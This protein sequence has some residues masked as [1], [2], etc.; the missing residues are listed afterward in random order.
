MGDSYWGGSSGS[1]GLRLLF[2]LTC[3]LLSAWEAEEPKPSFLV[4]EEL[5]PIAYKDNGVAKGVVVDIAQV[6]G[7][8]MERQLK[9]E[10]GL[11]RGPSLNVVGQAVLCF[12]SKS[13]PG[14]LV[15]LL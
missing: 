8:K 6:L 9:S 12:K 2:V 4:N 10:H 1:A 7:K 13:C 14:A 15:L 5:V 11:V 3:F